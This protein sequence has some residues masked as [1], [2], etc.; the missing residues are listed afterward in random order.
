M[1]KKL[2]IPINKFLHNYTLAVILIISLAILLQNEGILSSDM[3]DVQESWLFLF[4]L[5]LIFFVP[6][7][8]Y[9]L[10]KVLK[11]RGESSP[12]FIPSQKEKIRI[13]PL[14]I[15][16]LLS[17]FSLATLSLPIT[18]IIF[19]SLG[20]LLLF[21]RKKLWEKV[22]L[23]LIICIVRICITFLYLTWSLLLAR[24][25]ADFASMLIITFSPT[26]T[27]LFTF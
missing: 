15:I 23:N 16:T 6:I 8:I 24:V 19:I 2:F 17:L 9:K 27:Q 13:I 1:T 21:F 7:S 14:F 22:N 12:A 11:T 5:G 25:I 4:K 10:S 26:F 18:L 3:N 20:L